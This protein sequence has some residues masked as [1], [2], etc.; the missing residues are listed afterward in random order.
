M[1]ASDARAVFER[2]VAA[3]NARDV[4]A[5]DDLLH[6]DFQDF[7]PPSGEGT[8][9]T[10]NLKG[11]L[12]NYPGGFEGGGTSRVV[13]AQDRW[14]A[15]PAFTV[16][17]HRGHRQPSLPSSIRRRGDRNG[18]RSSSGR[19]PMHDSRRLADAVAEGYPLAQRHD[20]SANARRLLLHL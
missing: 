2:Y 10:E 9:G 13:G 20:Q 15:T 8:R 16:L 18:L 14:V 4:D 11:I 5:L 3:G 1:S 7:Y 19:N 17:R 12:R 6:P